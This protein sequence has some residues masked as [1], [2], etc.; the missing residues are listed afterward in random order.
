MLVTFFWPA[1]LAKTHFRF[2]TQATRKFLEYLPILLAVW[3]IGRVYSWAYW[4][5]LGSLG[6]LFPVFFVLTGYN[7]LFTLLH[8]ARVWVIEPVRFLDTWRKEFLVPTQ[9]VLSVTTGM[10]L[11]TYLTQRFGWVILLLTI[12]VALVAAITYV[13]PKASSSGC[14]PTN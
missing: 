11:T 7:L 1:F 10:G 2:P 9:F 12:P 14:L 5:R 13:G 8:A 4:Y 6:A 3:T